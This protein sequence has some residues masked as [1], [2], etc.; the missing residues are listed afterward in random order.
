MSVGAGFCPMGDPLRGRG[1]VRMGPWPGLRSGCTAP[2][3][4]AGESSNS[5][6][7]SATGGASAGAGW[8]GPGGSSGAGP[9]VSR[10]DDAGSLAVGDGI[11]A[12]SGSGAGLPGRS[13][14]GDT[15]LI[16]AGAGA[17]PGAGVEGTGAGVGT[18]GLG[19]CSVDGPVAVGLGESAGAFAG[20]SIGGAG[21]CDAFSGGAGS[22]SPGICS[23]VIVPAAGPGL[24]V[25]PK[26]GAA[27]RRRLGAMTRSVNEVDHAV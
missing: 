17:R 6:V 7:S 4:I 3:A 15:S 9:D 16:G 5:T 14:S 12:A 1:L 22:T 8:T 21:A 27:P 23:P 26:A 13:S 10:S 19:V 2:G 20:M 11:G 18:P 24:M 25:S